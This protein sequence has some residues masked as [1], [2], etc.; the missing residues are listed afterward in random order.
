MWNLLW[1]WS[2]PKIDYSR[3]LVW[4]RVNH[5]PNHKHLTRKDRLKRSLEKY[6][7]YKVGVTTTSST[8][9]P[10]RDHLHPFNIMPVTYILP[11]EYVT[12]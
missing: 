5:F 12:F 3:L 4:Q 9:R 2:A 7:Q 8:T 1:T 11:K 10:A 6:Y